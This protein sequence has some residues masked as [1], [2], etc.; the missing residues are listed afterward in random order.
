MRQ[1]KP[2]GAQCL[3]RVN[4][5]LHHRGVS[6]MQIWIQKG[7]AKE[8]GLRVCVWGWGGGVPMLAASGPELE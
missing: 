6:V 3:S 8:W 2:R 5:H 7:P 1:Q 4:P